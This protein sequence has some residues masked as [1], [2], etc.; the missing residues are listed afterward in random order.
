MSRSPR[1]PCP[2]CARSIAVVG[3]VLAR[4]D[5][6]TTLRHGLTSCP[7][8]LKA[9]VAPPLPGQTVL[10]VGG[11]GASRTAGQ[12]GLFECDQG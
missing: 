9:P 2:H 8:S 4:H 10:D 3:G 1:R 11:G 6:P 7:G 12:L 5:P